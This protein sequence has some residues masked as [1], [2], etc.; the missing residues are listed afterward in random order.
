MTENNTAHETDEVVSK[1]EFG[2]ILRDFL[3]DILL[4]FPE[5]ENTLDENLRAIVESSHDDNERIC[6]VQKQLESVYPEKFFDILYQNESIFEQ[7]TELYL[8]PGLDFR[9]LWKE[10]LSDS[11]RE[12][13]WK[14]LQLIMFTVVSGLSDSSSFGDTAKLFEAI[15]EETF[16]EKLEK[17]ISQMQSCFEENNNKTENDDSNDTPGINLED[18]PDPSSI[19][20]HVSGMMDGK[21]GN[22]AREIAEET[23]HEMEVDMEDETSVGDVFQKLLKDP[24]KL[25]SLVQKV[26][27]K[28]D[29]KIKAGELKESELLEEAGSIMQ[30]MKNMPG[31]SNIQS[32]FGGMASGSHGGKMNMGAMQAHLERNAK[33]ARQRERMKQKVNNKKNESVKSGELNIEKAV[34]TSNIAIADLLR[35]E[36][37]NEEGIQQMIYSTG[38]AYNKSSRSDNPSN[39]DNATVNER[40]KKRKKKKGKK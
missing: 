28:L 32:M 21:L 39:A 23:A 17:T 31:M 40:K 15:D 10:N 9:L 30:K 16:K 13:I 12:T 18:L 5:L 7:D 25:M 29:E 33:A 4:T 37:V 6:F 11:T 3:K 20:E 22:L 14:Y 38:E 35:C 2:K 8:L 24:T 36:G 26:G 1:Q 34:E 19:H 27:G